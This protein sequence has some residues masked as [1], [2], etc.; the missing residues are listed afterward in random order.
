[1]SHAMNYF[2]CC[3]KEL[4]VDTVDIGDPLKD[5]KWGNNLVN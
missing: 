3:A 2:M 4:K 5:L 1:M